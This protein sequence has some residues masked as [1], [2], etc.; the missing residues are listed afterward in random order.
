MKIEQVGPVGADVF[1]ALHAQAFPEPW[2]PSEFHG[3]LLGLGAVGLVASE[4]EEP[5]GMVVLSAAGGEAEI[6]TLAVAPKARRRGIAG[7]LMKAAEEAARE[8]QSDVLFLE[9][10]ADNEP[11]RALYRALGFSQAGLRK[12]YYR[13]GGDALVLRR[14]LT[15]RT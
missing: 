1:A 11:A 15:D 8:K 9:V 2:A 12:A 6:L 7:A 13:S 4:N 5:V 3:L 10:A 14:L